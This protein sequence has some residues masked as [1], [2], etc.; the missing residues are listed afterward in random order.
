MRA[1]QATTTGFDKSSTR[2]CVRVPIAQLVESTQSTRG[3]REFWERIRFEKNVQVNTK[4]QS[5][6]LIR[7]PVRGLFVLLPSRR[8][9][10]CQRFC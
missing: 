7:R 8:R 1:K 5:R 10:C 3:G 4:K 2:H 6:T 9:S